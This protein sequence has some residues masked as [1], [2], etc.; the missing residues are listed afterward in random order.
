MIA[1]ELKTAGLNIRAISL[2][3]SKDFG[4]LR[5]I[6]QD[7][8][9]ACSVLRAANHA[10]K[11]TDVVAVEVPDRPGGLADLLKTLEG[12]EV[13]IEYMYAVLEKRSENAVIILKVEDIDGVIAEMQKLNIKLLSGG[14]VY[15]AL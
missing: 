11:E 15:G 12:A 8:D 6:V 1:E 4:V 14:E 10:V 7:P 5:M 13:N 2:A 3:D 9:K